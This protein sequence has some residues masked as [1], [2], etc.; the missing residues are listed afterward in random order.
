MIRISLRDM[1]WRRRRYII[2][3]L[4]AALAF[5]LALTMTGLTNQLHREG[6][7][8]VA[9]FNA[10]QW[11]V[12]DGVSGPFTSSQLIDRRIAAKIADQDGVVTASPI[13]IG[14]TVIDSV[15]VNVIG[16]DPSSPMLPAR[17]VEARRKASEPNGA[18]ADES[19][20]K[21]VGDLIPLGG[22]D[23]PV[24]AEVR[25][26]AFFFSA[27]T[28]F[29]PLPAVQALLFAGQDVASSVVIRGRVD[30][31]SADLS[32]VDV[33]SNADVRADFSRA[34]KSTADT[35]SIVNVLLWLMAAGTVAAIIFVSVL[36]RTREYATLKAIGA[37]TASLLGG[38]VVQ[39]A[40]I[41][42]VS[43][44]A[45]FGVSR[46]IAPTFKFPVSTPLGAYV[47]LVVIAA[48]VGVVA[49]L[50]GLRK[51]TRIDPALAFGGAS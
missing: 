31:N 42:V 13:L 9:L 51:I 11:V 12:A 44:V 4:V 15:D 16:Y 38:L 10:D 36:E 47:Q 26:T 21:R 17:L 28:V 33:L 14:R 48:I 1:Q 41:S 22:T 37:S 45:A 34:I 19:L 43:A 46:A 6:V 25:D 2:V 30:A 49:S 32:T 29:L 8:T 39:A 40:L 5:G 35:I 3:V 50:A 18:I 23:V 7:N 27:P 20:R 24:V